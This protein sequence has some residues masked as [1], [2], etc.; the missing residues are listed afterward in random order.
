MTILRRVL[1]SCSYLEEIMSG[2]A[3]T[4]FVKEAMTRTVKKK[5]K[6]WDYIVEKLF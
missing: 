5:S 4:E 1:N 2:D 3:L 6:I